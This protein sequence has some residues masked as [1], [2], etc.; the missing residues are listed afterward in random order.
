MNTTTNKDKDDV[1]TAEAKTAAEQAAASRAKE[2]QAKDAAKDKD[3]PKEVGAIVNVGDEG[4]K[5]QLAPDTGGYINIAERAQDDKRFADQ[6]DEDGTIPPGTLDEMQAGRDALDRRNG[7]GKR[8]RLDD[9][10]AADIRTQ[11]R[12]RGEDKL[13]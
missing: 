11:R 5:N 6:A 10:D 8:R 1:K 9:A 3:E 4:Y 7:G 2:A 12:E 13:K